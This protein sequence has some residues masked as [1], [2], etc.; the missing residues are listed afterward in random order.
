MLKNE[1]K[2]VNESQDTIGDQQ[3]SPGERPLTS[4]QRAAVRVVHNEGLI[5]NNKP[6]QLG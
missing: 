5:L 4:Y 2:V 1:E 6:P 3:A